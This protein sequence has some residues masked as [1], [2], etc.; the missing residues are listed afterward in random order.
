MIDPYFPSFTL[1]HCTGGLERCGK[2]AVEKGLIYKIQ[3]D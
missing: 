2:N 3:S 1:F